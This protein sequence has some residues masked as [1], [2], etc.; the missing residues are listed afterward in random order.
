MNLLNLTS[1]RL[2]AIHHSLCEMLI[3]NGYQLNHTLYNLP[4]DKFNSEIK[5]INQ[6]KI[7]SIKYFIEHKKELHNEKKIKN[8]AIPPINLEFLKKI[9][10]RIPK[11][12]Y[13]FLCYELAMS[14][15][16]LRNSKLCLIMWSTLNQIGKPN[17]TCL[18]EHLESLL[19]RISGCELKLET[20]IFVSPNGMT[21]QSYNNLMPTFAK[22][23]NC[24]MRLFNY[25]QLEINC[26]KLKHY[27]KQHEKLS[28]EEVKNFIEKYDYDYKDLTQRL[29]SLI[30][31]K[32]WFANYYDF[33]EGDFIRV[34]NIGR[35]DDYY[36]V[37]SGGADDN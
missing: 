21:P 3:D 25:A 24:K 26:K 33:Q 9:N 7:E 19:K 23:F 37:K 14:F 4:L 10:D 18:F 15:F 2:H 34:K 8:K 12:H 31:G 27:Y 17:F 29:I 30:A 1:E 6:A 13:D 35:A 16:A 20:I 11:Y 32:D 36:I 5:K 28:K 22:L